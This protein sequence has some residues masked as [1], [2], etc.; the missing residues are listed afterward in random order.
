LAREGCAWAQELGAR[1]LVIWPATDGYDYS[2]SVNYSRAWDSA[3]ASYRSIARECAGVQV[4]L[5]WKPTDEAARFSIVASTGAALLL[6][7]QVG[8]PNFGLT[9]DFGHLLLAGENPA[10]SIDMVASRGKLFGVHLNDGYQRLG[11]EDG[12]AW[13]TV[14]PTQALEAVWYLQQHQYGGHVYFDT[15]PNNEDP[16][17]EAQ[18]NIRQFTRMWERAARLR[19]ARALEGALE[20]HDAMR[21]MEVLEGVR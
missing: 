8:E 4:S 17:R 21:A 13:G 7:E 10:Q 12:L 3:V 19:D 20:D 14:H 11:A 5:E 2:F 1:Q 9:L 18:F 15:F 6:V 16:V